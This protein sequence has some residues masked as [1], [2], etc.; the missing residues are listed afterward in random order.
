MLNLPDHE[1]DLREAASLSVVRGSMNGDPNSRDPIDAL[2]EEHQ[3]FLVRLRSF[4]TDVRRLTS[5]SAADPSLPRCV[6]DFAQFLD[7]DVTRFHGRKEEEGLFPVLGRHIPADEGPIGVM[8]A[9]HQFLKD[10]QDVLYR[11]ARRV[12]SDPEA[13]ESV[14]AIAHSSM[15]VETTL[16]DHIDK[17]DHVLFPMARSLLSNAEISEVAEICRRVERRLQ[18]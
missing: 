17:E 2:M 7:R 5:E 11:N 8:L 12:E 4:R 3:R 6:L 18:S 1:E 9:E 16:R 15:T 14:N 10:Q 13:R